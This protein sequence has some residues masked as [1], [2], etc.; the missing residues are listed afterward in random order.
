MANTRPSSRTLGDLVD[1]VAAATPAAPAI[2]FGDERLDYGALKRRVDDFARA[3][4]ATGVCRG[5]RVALLS[6]N[7]TEWIVAALAIARIGAIVA[8]V[9]TFSTPRELAWTLEHCGA[10]A[11]VMLSSFRGRS[12]LD[13]LVA[14]CPELGHCA[15]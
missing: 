8:A 15:A 12:F 2:V 4:L 5:D 6:S 3:L 1:A 11:L 7:R 10:S 9:S 13:P 14:L